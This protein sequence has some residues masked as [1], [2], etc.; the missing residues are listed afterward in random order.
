MTKN[1]IN[2]TFPVGRLVQGDV[3][4][5]SSKNNDGTARVYQ[6]GPKA[7]QPRPPEYFVAVAI[8]KIAGHTH[9]AQT[10][11]GLKIWNLA[12]QLWPNGQTQR[13]DFAWKITD[14]DSTIPNK[15]QRRP[16]DSEG[17]PGH[18]VVSMKTQYALKVYNAD[19]SQIILEPGAVKRGYYI[20]VA[21][22]VDSN[23]STQTA[24]LYINP[25]LVALSGFGAEIT[26]G[27]DVASAG[28][29]GALPPGASAT[30]VGGF[31][32][33]AAPMGAPPPIPGQAYMPP[34]Y[35]P[36]AA[37]PVAAR[38]PQ[39]AVAPAPGFVPAAAPT[40]PPPPPAPPA[41]PAA[42]AGPQMTAAANGVTYAAMIAAGWTDQSLRQHGYLV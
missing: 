19:G 29:G 15:N 17:F 37:P 23:E 16:V 4:T 25:Q 30:P 38:P 28:F 27:M 12:A 36:P 8:P 2:I 26:S 33:P 21:A 9:W 35:T 1:A 14:G 32:P 24:G 6:S 13:A 3:Y 39:T 10:D 18:W 42:P 5:P 11:W 7:G 31:T 34:G 40:P 22:T 41:A 20:Q